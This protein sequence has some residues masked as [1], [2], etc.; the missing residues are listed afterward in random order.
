M[1]R[2]V[3]LADVGHPKTDRNHRVLMALALRNPSPL[4]CRS[5]DLGRGILLLESKSGKSLSRHRSIWPC[6]TLPCPDCV[7]VALAKEEP[8]PSLG[9]GSAS[10]NCRNLCRT[11]SQLLVAEAQFH[12]SH[13]RLHGHFF[14][15][16]LG[17]GRGTRIVRQGCPALDRDT[18]FHSR[19][20]DPSTQETSLGSPL[21]G[22]MGS[23]HRPESHDGL[24]VGA[25]ARPVH[26]H[27]QRWNSLALVVSLAKSF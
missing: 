23:R 12:R 4:L 16:K 10:R 11:R 20:A 18:G 27:M 6:S 15:R 2:G 19:R 25:M 21:D 14:R 17:S 5:M 3:G 24:R 13:S 8:G 26:S 7:A 1:D 22:D 9:V